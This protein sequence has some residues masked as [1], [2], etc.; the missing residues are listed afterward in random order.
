MFIQENCGGL[1]FNADFAGMWVNENPQDRI[2]AKS[3]TIFV[4][5]VTNCP[6]LWAQ[7][8][9]TDITIYTLNYECVSVYHYVGYLL[10]LKIL[11]KEV[12]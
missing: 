7:N 10:H 5:K 8:I 6:I 9:Q 12:I 11:I 4:V 1:L 3:K 2:S